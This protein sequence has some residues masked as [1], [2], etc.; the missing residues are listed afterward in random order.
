MSYH[1][2]LGNRLPTRVIQTPRLV[3]ATGISLS[4]SGNLPLPC[5]ECVGSRVWKPQNTCLYIHGSTA[6]CCLYRTEFEERYR[7]YRHSDIVI[8]I[9]N[10]VIIISV[11]LYLCSLARR[12]KY[13]YLYL[14]KIHLC[15]FH[16]YITKNILY[17]YTVIIFP[18]K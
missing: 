6:F 10:W 17:I 13:I 9:V 7:G 2:S 8:L 15:L 4:V 14:F 18:W 5:E 11:I 1:A 3:N 12:L 16:K